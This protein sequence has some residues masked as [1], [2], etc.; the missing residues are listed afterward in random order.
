M[1]AS[2]FIELVKKSPDADR[3]KLKAL[4]VKRLMAIID[5]MRKL[6]NDR[7]G[8]NVLAGRK[9]IS[10][11]YFIEFLSSERALNSEIEYC[12]READM[13]EAG[14]SKVIFEQAINFWRMNLAKQN[15]A[16]GQVA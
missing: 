15:P 11:D 14:W 10:E 16:P 9:L 13:L 8:L 5:P 1:N 3:K 2:D 7:T 4:L 6:Q 12:F